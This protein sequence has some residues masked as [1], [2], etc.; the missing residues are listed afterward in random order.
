MFVGLLLEIN[1]DEICLFKN[2]V[3]CFYCVKLNQKMLN[4]QIYSVFI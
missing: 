2:E 1:L 3:F 4:M